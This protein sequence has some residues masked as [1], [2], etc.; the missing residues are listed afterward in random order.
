MRIKLSLPA[1][2][3]ILT[4]RE[5]YSMVFETLDNGYPVCIKRNFSREI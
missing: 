4:P 3:L 5:V 1:L 2:I